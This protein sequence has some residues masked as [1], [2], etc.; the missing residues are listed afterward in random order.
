[1]AFQTCAAS[2]IFPHIY[3]LNKPNASTDAFGFSAAAVT[4]NTLDVYEDWMVAGG[5]YEMTTNP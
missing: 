3:G 1:M 2:S 5:K 4:F